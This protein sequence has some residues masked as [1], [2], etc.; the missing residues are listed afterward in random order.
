MARSIVLKRDETGSIPITPTYFY[1]GGLAEWFIAAVLKMARDANLSLG[2]SNLP[3]SV[4]AKTSAYM[5]YKLSTLS[6]IVSVYQ[7]LHYKKGG[8]YD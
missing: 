7:V 4:Y 1:I 3:A 5:L 6:K 2:R 8:Q